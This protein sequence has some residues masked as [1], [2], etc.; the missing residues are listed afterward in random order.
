MSNDRA[1]VVRGTG[2][3]ALAEQ[4]S[5]YSSG[6]S[7]ETTG[8]AELWLGIISLPP[9]KR[10]AA[11]H[12]AAHETALYMMSGV[13]VDLYTGPALERHDHLRPG[14]YLF[15]PAGLPHVAINHSDATAVFMGRTNRLPCKRKRSDAACPRRGVRKARRHAN[16]PQA[17]LKS[18]TDRALRRPLWV[19][20]VSKRFYRRVRPNRTGNRD[21]LGS[22][23]V[24]ASAGWV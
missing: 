10:T 12:H 17:P 3:A 11:H 14:D 15:I 4:G 24:G 6:V 7:A 20:V 18:S 2:S 19:L 5:V 16:Q 23:R 22:V 21:R 8:A 13:E 1:V 9:G